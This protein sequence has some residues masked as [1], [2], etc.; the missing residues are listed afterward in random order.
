MLAERT[1]PLDAT[2]PVVLVTE[3]G[4]A[5]YDTILPV[6]AFPDLSVTTCKR[7]DK[8]QFCR[9]RWSSSAEA[10]SSVKLCACPS[11]RTGMN[12]VRSRKYV[13]KSKAPYEV[14]G[15]FEAFQKSVRYKDADRETD[16]QAV[17]MIPPV[18]R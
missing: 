11:T 1:K 16:L 3:N 6:V 2:F 14:I 15:L 18:Y 17:G 9:V 13:G 8:N 12:G 4:C 10:I 5:E 7:P